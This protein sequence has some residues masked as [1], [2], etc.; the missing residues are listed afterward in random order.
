MRKIFLESELVL[1]LYLEQFLVVVESKK[2]CADFALLHQL[3]SA[4]ILV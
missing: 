2:F 3:Y 1:D 4:K